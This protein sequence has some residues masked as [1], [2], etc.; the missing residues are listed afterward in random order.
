MQCQWARRLTLPRVCSP[1]E[2]NTLASCEQCST[3]V[4][5]PLEWSMYIRYIEISTHSRVRA[6]GQEPQNASSRAGF[7]PD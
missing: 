6:G 2:V 4:P 1:K 7:V 5:R 3:G